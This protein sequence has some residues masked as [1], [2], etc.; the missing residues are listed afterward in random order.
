[1][2]KFKTVKRF[3]LK[4][5]GDEWKD[6]YVDFE[7]VSIADVQNVFPKFR[8]VDS[9]NDKEVTEGI[10]NMVNFLKGK[11]VGGKGVVEKEGLVDLEINDLEN[12]PAEVLS[13]ALSFLSEGVTPVTPKP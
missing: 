13:R 8:T 5:L 10:E 4:F 9:K 1:M 12:L 2:K 11:F 3:S 6:A 7:R